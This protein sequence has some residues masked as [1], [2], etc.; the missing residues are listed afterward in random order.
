VNAAADLDA[1]KADLPAMLS[2]LSVQRPGNHLACCF[3][4]NADALSIHHAEAGWRF[5]CHRCGAAGTLVDAVALLERCT[6]ADAIKRLCGTS[7]TPKAKP[8]FAPAP[9]A[10]A[11]PPIPDRERLRRFL[12]CAQT[13]LAASEVALGFVAKRGLTLDAC[14]ALGL[15]FVAEARFKEWPGCP[16]RNAW[17]IPVS[18]PSGKEYPAFA[19]EAVA[20]KLHL[21]APPPKSP[22]SLW[23]P[24]G[25]DRDALTGK[26]RNGLA[27]LWPCPESGEF[28]E[29]CAI[30]EAEARLSAE[31]ATALAGAACGFLYL[32]EGELKAAACIAAGKD[33]VSVTAGASFRWTPGL[34]ARLTGRRVCVLFDDDN[35]GRRFRDTALTALAN[36]AL[37]LKAVTFGRKEGHNA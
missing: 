29:R 35:A 10:E 28:A 13:E 20:I 31:D 21:E 17:V 14:N 16:L 37:E 34:L 15:G 6:P 11:V 3:C 33:A 26:T 2:T 25:T 4:G 32:T 8:H 1:L 9:P 23:A 18:Y 27:T 7:Y 5:R 12:A 36:A 24:F 19:A 30:L 22:K